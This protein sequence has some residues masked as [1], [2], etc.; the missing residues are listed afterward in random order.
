MNENRDEQPLSSWKEIGAYLQRNEATARRWEREE[1]LPVHRHPHKSRSSVYAYPSELNAWRQ[2][3]KVVAQPL[4]L[5]KTLFTP[6]RSLA[7]G[8]TLALCL[9]MVGN[10]VRPRT[11]SAQDAGMTTRRVW[12]G[13]E[14]NL[15]GAPSPDGRFLTYTDWGPPALA[16]RNLVTGGTRP[17]TIGSWQVGGEWPTGPSRFSPDGR[18]VI[19]TWFNSV[20]QFHELRIAPID[21]G[22]AGGTARVLFSNREFPYL[23]PTGWSPDGK[24]ILA[25]LY[26]KDGTAQIAL[27]SV[28][29]GSA[30]TLKSFG[31]N[32]PGHL[33]FSPDGR[34]IAYNL[35]PHPNAGTDILVMAADGSREVRLIDHP[36]DD[37]LLGWAP[38]GKHILFSSDRT[39]TRDAWLVEV[40]EGRASREPYLVKRDI[41]RIVPMSFTRNGSF[42]YGLSA[43]IRDIYV[44][45]VDPAPDKLPPEPRLA[46]QRFLGANRGPS[47]SPGADSM[48]YFMAPGGHG[49]LPTSLI[50]RDLK[51]GQE[52]TL[53]TDLRP[54][55]NIR[56]R[57]SP[58][59]RWLLVNSRNERG[60]S[61]LH[62]VNA[63]TGA[64]TPLVRDESLW[65]VWTADGKA[66]IY[67]RDASPGIIRIRDLV[68]GEDKE[69]F[70]PA[71]P[72]RV[73]NLA[74]SPDGRRLA[75]G[76]S[77]VSQIMGQVI[78]VLPLHDRK[79]RE[80][81]RTTILQ[82]GQ[83]SGLDWAPDGRHLFFARSRK[84]WRIPADGG[85]PQA[86]AGLSPNGSDGFSVHPDGRRIAFVAGEQKDEVWVMENFLPKPMT[87]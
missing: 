21:A 62:Q 51:T 20:E 29:D 27:V 6:P 8:A 32:A 37:Q 35:R 81:M 19:S 53:R 46:S 77:Q 64:M 84:M 30:K 12:T 49:R 13:R 39:G 63:Q 75:F 58:D 65:G 50:V 31:W 23:H 74:L 9:V 4:P 15:Y 14:V 2:G 52:R 7:F 70:R 55:L 16:I 80:L 76:M 28:E 36:A 72:M 24:W 44:G 57:W 83:F 73:S 85:E 22:A 5:W 66:L 67:A 87:R 45:A 61:S 78:M 69:L 82:G 68:T 60:R 79:P 34:Y 41:G 47:W 25:T 11:A 42:Y 54:N 33:N 17:L 1:G 86:I 71:E 56:P 38:D 18:Q 59:G 40:V 26:R 48:A 43:G 10:G 3:R